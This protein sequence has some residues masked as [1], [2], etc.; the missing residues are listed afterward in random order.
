M[1]KKILNFAL[2]AC[3]IVPCA[4]IMAGCD[5]NQNKAGLEFSNSVASATE[6][7]ITDLTN[8]YYNASSLGT[9]TKYSVSQI[10][11][12]DQDFVYY[13][14]V[15]KLSNIDEVSSIAIGDVTFEADQTFNLSIGNA[16]Y[17]EDK[18][19]YEEEGK[20]YVAAP[21]VAFET[22]NNGKIKVNDNEFSFNLDKIAETNS[23]TSAA[24]SSG[25]TNA[26]TNNEDGSF[27]LEMKDAKTY[28]AL[29]FNN[30]AASDVV[31]TKKVVK[32][33]G[34]ANI[35]GKVNYGLTKVENYEGYPLGFYPIGYSEGALSESFTTSYDG[36]TIEYQAYVLNK[37]IFTAMLNID[38]V[39]E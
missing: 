10:K 36:A 14:E 12:N 19:F 8:N 11:T 16:N 34:N 29:F 25:S 21:I 4:G 5:F 37:G 18:C 15:G 6:S 20:L 2:A 3:M 24:F 32:N 27:D 9:N 38:I 31:L 33:S 39:S 22:V 1:N 35:N 28:L 30:A 23:F 17:I 26:V 7:I 13:V